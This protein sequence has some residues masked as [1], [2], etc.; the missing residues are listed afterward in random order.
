MHRLAEI[1]LGDCLGVMPGLEAESFDAIVTDPPYGL[2]FM[3]KDWDSFRV[4]PRAARWASRSGAA[5]HIQ[6][7]GLL[8]AD[9]PVYTKRR[10]TSQCQTCGKRDAF[11]NPH[12]CGELADWRTIPVDTVNVE[13]RA[14]QEWT[15]RWAAEAYRIAKPGAW[16]LAFG[17]TRTYHRLAAG[18]EDAGWEIRDCLVWAYAQGF[19]KSLNVAAAVNARGG[20]GAA[21]ADWGTALKPAWEPILLARKPLIGSVAENV[22]KLGPGA[23]NIGAGRIPYEAGAPDVP[24]IVPGFVQAGLFGDDAPLLDTA[25]QP[26]ELEEEPAPSPYDVNGR[27]PA[28]VILTAPIFDGDVPGVVGG[29]WALPVESAGAYSRFFLIPKADRLEREPMFGGLEARPRQARYGS[30]QDGEPI[31]RDGRTVGRDL[32]YGYDRTA[33]RNHHPTVKPLELMRHLC[34]LVTPPGGVILDP[35]LGSG[36]TA[37]AAEGE[38]FRWLGIERDPEYAGIAHARLL[39]HQQ[40]L[41]L[42]G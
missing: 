10:T 21:W 6:H 29:S 26:A 11:R 37:L 16:M 15:T 36:T 8:G 2:E 4:D 34:R 7:S 17:G 28:N 35:F 41:G 24:A 1:L 30:V 40:G 14:Y 9:L 27:W 25:L 38:G 33:R 12:K 31:I 23:L 3:G 42:G 13:L 18:V 22:T 39:G 19:P 20:D 32:N 5:G